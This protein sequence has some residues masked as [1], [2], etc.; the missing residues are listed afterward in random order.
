MKKQ[1]LKILFIYIFI[2]CVSATSYAQI[3]YAPAKELGRIKDASLTE[4][5]GVASSYN[6]L[7]TF[8]VHND[9]GDSPRIFLVDKS[10]NTLT[11]GTL[12]NATARD[13]EDI[14]S[15]KLKGKSY[16]LVADIGDNAQKRKQYNLYIIKEPNYNPNG[17]NPEF[18][19]VLRRINF[20]YDTGSQNCESIAVDVKSR[21]I[22]L[23]S[24]SN[25]Q[26]SK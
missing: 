18:Y 1:T 4:I 23:V 6:T 5:S 25:Y 16:I 19:P 2:F 10:G 8:W 22:L 14:A 17:S 3:T 9:S 26:G 24:K 13:W 15:F 12:T 20:T 7:G 21:K 11:K